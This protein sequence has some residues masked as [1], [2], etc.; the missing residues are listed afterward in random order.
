RGRGGG[1]PRWAPGLQVLP[2]PARKGYIV[3]PRLTN[4]RDL[5]DLS[6]GGALAT[7]RVMTC[8]NER[9]EYEVTN[10]A[11]RM[12]QGENTVVDNF[13]AGGILAKVDIRTRVRGR[14]PDR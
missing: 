8:R 1:A 3:Q 6:N 9:G 5:R 10:A 2:P 11:F 4:H 12:A 7:V 14:S 13:H